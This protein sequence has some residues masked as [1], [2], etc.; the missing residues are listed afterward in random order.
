MTRSSLATTHNSPLA[1]GEELA[2]ALHRGQAAV[3]RVARH[4]ADGEFALEVGGGQWRA[5]VAQRGEDGL[6]RRQQCRVDVAGARAASCRGRAPARGRVTPRATSGLAVT[7]VAR[8]VGFLARILLACGR[9]G[10]RDLG[11]FFDKCLVEK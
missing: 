10:L 9:G 5:G 4:R 6:A 1:V 11:G 7:V 2:V 8:G 3:E